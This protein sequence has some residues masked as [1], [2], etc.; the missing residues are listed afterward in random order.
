MH[1]QL[2]RG[3]GPT[4]PLLLC[5][6]AT[7]AQKNSRIWQG[8]ST[9]GCHLK[10]PPPTRPHTGFFPTCLGHPNGHEVLPAQC[11]VDPGLPQ[12]HDEQAGRNAG[13]RPEG[14]HVAGPAHADVVKGG[15]KGRAGVDLQPDGKPSGYP[16]G[17]GSRIPDVQQTI[18]QTAGGR[19]SSPL[20][21]P[22]PPPLPT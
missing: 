9:C 15:G 11:H 18:V 17:N 3:A 2:M 7:D 10:H 21:P 19:K 13:H 20:P 6:I 14:D 16:L 1:E 12:Q 8:E 22:I 5:A 4:G